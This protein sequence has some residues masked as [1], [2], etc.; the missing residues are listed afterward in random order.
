MLKPVFKSAALTVVMRMPEHP[1]HRAYRKHLQEGMEPALARLTLARRIAAAVLAMRKNQEDY[2][3][4][5]HD[6]KR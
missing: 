5:K 6:S 2:D 1:L 4:T 3:P